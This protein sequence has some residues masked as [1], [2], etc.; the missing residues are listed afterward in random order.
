MWAE[1]GHVESSLAADVTVRLQMLPSPFLI[2]LG[3]NQRCPYLENVH[4]CL[5]NANQA[6]NDVDPCLKKGCGG[7]YLTSAVLP[8]I[9]LGL[10]H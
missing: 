7:A 6:Q 5:E 1:L 2:P 9:F 3:K 8:G 4:P 10:F